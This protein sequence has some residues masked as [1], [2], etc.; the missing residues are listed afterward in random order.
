MLTD[1][2]NQNEIIFRHPCSY[3]HHQNGLIERKYKHRV[4]LGLTL[5]AQANLPFK[6]LWHVVH[7]AVYH[8]NSLPTTVFK[9]ISPYEKLFKHKSNYNFLRCFGCLCYPYM[10]DF[11][12]H[13]FDFHTSKC[14]F[15]GYNPSHKGYKCLINFSQ[16]HILR[17]VVFDETTSLHSTNNALSSSETTQNLKL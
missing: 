14:I 6:F 16:I 15:I 9:L 11:N 2:L 7:T 10:R 12:K 5:M 3:T 1:F 17:H 13:K 4:E 8:I